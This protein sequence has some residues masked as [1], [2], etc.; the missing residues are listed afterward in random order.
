MSEQGAGAGPNAQVTMTNPVLEARGVARVFQTKAERLEVLSGVD[1]AVAGGEFVSIVGP[2]GT[3]KST[4]LHILGGLDRPTAGRVMLESQDIFGYPE[5]RLPGLRNEKVGFVFQFHHLLAE[6]TVLENVALPRLVAGAGEAEAFREA[7]QVLS[8][9]GF[10]NR[11]THRPAQLSGGEKSKAAVARALVN[12]PA[13]VLADEPTGSLDAA[14]SRQL[15]DLLVGLNRERG[16]TLVAVTHNPDV[17][18][19]AR[20]TLVMR[21]GRLFDDEEM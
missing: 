1:L 6:F 18:K 21:E 4:L 13:V 15:M 16:L 8:E 9:I 2:S 3:G 17:A 7:E 14:S 20:R 11:L 12:R 19:L 5:S 10:T